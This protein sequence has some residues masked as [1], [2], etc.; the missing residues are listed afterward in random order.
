[1]ESIRD[2]ATFFKVLRASGLLTDDQLLVA[3]YSEA[4]TATPEVIGRHL[5]ELGWL[6]EWQLQHLMS[7]RTGF[8][9]GGYDLQQ[10]LGR[11]RM[12]LVYRA[13][14]RSTGRAVAV[15]IMAKELVGDS[16][17]VRRFLREIRLVAQTRHPHIVTAYDAGRVADGRYYLVTEFVP[18]RDLAQ[19]LTAASPLPVGWVCEC[20]YQAALGLQHAADN[21]L[22]H[23]DI[24]P[25]NMMVIADSVEAYPCVKI[26]D[27]GLGRFTADQ[28]EENDLTRD[29]FTLGTFEFAA[30]EQIQD[31][32]AAD[33]RSDLYSL[34]CA[35]FQ[36]LTGRY[37][38]E[39]DTLVDRITAKFT[40]DPPC[41]CSL[42]SDV[43][44]G[45]DDVVQWMMHRDRDQRPAFRHAWSARTR[46]GH[47]AAAAR[48]QR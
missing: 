31:A 30:P 39:G 4:E 43:P 13:A 36:L 8:H 45:L 44:E 41:V 20:I 2:K 10:F 1:V 24:K 23:R 22:V 15:K 3:E 26:L 46:R 12:G 42:R 5:I 16:R 7:G 40:Q 21:G 9:I 32:R 27:L 6:T 37:P 47:V 48:Q 14:Q 19:W 17:S 35:L 38:H 25:A 29:G 18:G 11:G 33:V 28:G 34:G